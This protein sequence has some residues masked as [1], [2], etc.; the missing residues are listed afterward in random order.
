MAVVVKYNERGDAEIK[1]LNGVGI[2]AEERNQ[3]YALDAV[4]KQELTFLV[5]RLKK[6][7]A[8]PK[9]REKG[10]VEAYWEF[11]S[12]LRNI[13]LHSELIKQSEKSFF[14]ESVKYYTELL[15]AKSLLAED[16]SGA[17]NHLDY[18]F[19]LSGYPKETALALQWS[20]WN[21]LFDSSSI[22][23]EIRFD[24]WFR[25]IIKD[26]KEFLDR[27]TLRAFAKILN[28]L[29]KD[30]ETRDWKTE[31]LLNCYGGAWKILLKLR[32]NKLYKQ[33]DTRKKIINAVRN[34]AKQNKIFFAQLIDGNYSDEEYSEKICDCSIESS[35]DET[36]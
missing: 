17:R 11:G 7:D 12:V 13:L 28:A 1:S 5:K 35:R 31:Q 25:K 20:E 3:A 2:S 22:N 32:S 8:L 9:Q 27:D 16:R 21:T 4:T 36:I 29:I 15:D 18:C 14:Y 30:I 34:C 6:E 24:E 26:N 10:K 23:R 19:R 33:P